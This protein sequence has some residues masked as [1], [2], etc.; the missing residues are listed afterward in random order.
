L[1]AGV[2]TVSH[3]N[4]ERSG[5]RIKQGDWAEDIRKLRESDVAWAL[6][7]TLQDKERGIYSVNMLKKRDDEFHVNQAVTVLTSLT[8]GRPCLDSAPERRA[9]K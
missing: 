4:T 9:I 3:S 5:K 6:N 8:I 7:Q 2:I 1:H